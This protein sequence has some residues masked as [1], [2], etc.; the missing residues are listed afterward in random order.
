MT[1]SDRVWQGIHDD[2]PTDDDGVPRHPEKGYPICG[3]PKTDAVDTTKDGKREDIPYCLQAAGWGT[4]RSTGACKAHGGAGGAPSGWANGNAR[5]LM[6]SDRMND[7]DREQ[8]RQLVDVGDGD[9]IPIDEFKTTLSNMVAFEEMR[10]QRAIDKHPDVEQIQLYRCPEC[11]NTAR[12]PEPP[13]SCDGQVKVGGGEYI[14]CEF[15]GEFESIP[16]KS[17]IHFGDE[18]FERK[19][20]HIANL[21]QTLD[22]VSG[23][24]EYK[25]DQN[26]TIDGGDD[27]I[28]VNITS[29]GVDLAED[30]RVDDD[31]EG[32]DGEDE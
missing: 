7:D 4:E 12:R 26:T 8:F 27:P 5:H 18:A 10:L 31:E 20:R 13:T 9:H 2:A 23:P 17:W 16:G 22:K 14:P 15:T 28:E 24:A 25:V 11:G 21:I 30:E 1:D 6:Y 19:Q 32:D 29:V 3:Q